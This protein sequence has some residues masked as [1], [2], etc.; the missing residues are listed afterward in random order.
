MLDDEKD[1]TKLLRMHD[2]LFTSNADLIKI[3]GE[4]APRVTADGT[5]LEALVLHNDLAI[6]MLAELRSKM[7]LLEPLL[8]RILGA[9]VAR[10]VPFSQE[11]M[12]T[13]RDPRLRS[14]QSTPTRVPIGAETW[15]GHAA[16]ESPANA[17]GIVYF[18]T[19]SVL[20]RTREKPEAK[21]FSILCL[22]IPS[23]KGKC[24]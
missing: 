21:K 1:I 24:W 6:E 22:R 13:T 2:R 7:V 15:E 10:I 8:E 14:F 3:Y 5:G 19:G 18:S 17:P 20:H 4:F 11:R 9:P 16:A 12:L 23:I